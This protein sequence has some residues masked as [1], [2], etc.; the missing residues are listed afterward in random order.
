MRPTVDP[1]NASIAAQFGEA[2]A[3]LEAQGADALRVAAY[4]RGAESLRGLAEPAADTLWRRGRAGLERIPDVGRSLARSI[5]E[6][7]QTNRW[8]L[9]DRLRGE[10]N[11]LRTLATVRGIGPELARRIHE[12]LGIETLGDLEATAR[13]G[14]LATIEGL[15][16]CKL[17]GVRDSLAG[18][19]GR[20]TSPVQLVPG[21]EDQPST[22][23]LLDVDAEYRRGAAS[24]ALARIAP[25]RCNRGQAEYPVLHTRRGGRHYTA[26]YSNTARR[27]NLGP[28]R[29]RVVI[30]RDDHGGGGQWTVLTAGRGSRRGDR[31]VIGRDAGDAT[32]RHRSTG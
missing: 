27:P 1:S 16:P 24:D 28:T 29:D 14:R 11:P 15:G 8:G 26:L 23:E 21:P 20:R 22:S 25:R 9:L 18:R 12:G 3:L 7:V 19:L 4:R 6:L 2:A 30:Y 5:E 17:R 10:Q 32:M 31:V 13:D